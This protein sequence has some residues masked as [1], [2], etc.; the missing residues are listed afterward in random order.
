MTD[1]VRGELELEPATGLSSRGLQ[2]LKASLVVAVGRG[3]RVAAAGR[4][5][6]LVL[7]QTSAVQ[8]VAAWC[9]L[10]GRD[11]KKGLRKKNM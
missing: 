9:R 5:T 8:F 4:Q 7:E 1:G 11:I 10:E 6:F 3:G 2:C